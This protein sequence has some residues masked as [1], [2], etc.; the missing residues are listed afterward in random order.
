MPVVAATVLLVAVSGCHDAAT[1]GSEDRP[2]PGVV[3]WRTEAW[4]NLA[5]DVPAHW[6]W[7]TA[8]IAA[9]VDESTSLL[10]GGPG[11]TV[12]ADGSAGGDQDEAWVGRPISLSDVCLTTDQL[13]QPAAPYVWLGADVEPGTVD[14]GGGWVRETVVA[15]DSTLTVATDDPALRRSILESAHGVRRCFGV[16]DTPP[17]AAYGPTEGIRPVRSAEICAYRPEGDEWVLAYADTLDEAAAQATYDALF[18]GQRD[19]SPRFCKDAEEYVA[20]TFTGDDPFG[21]VPVSS[22]VVLSVD[23]RQVEVAPDLVAPLP[24]KALEPWSQNGVRTV[25]FGF[26]GAQG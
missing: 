22:R 21:S 3:A 16:L 23:C 14:L 26:I 24:E 13:G 12:R 9:G 5:V 18:A 10:C 4:R 17:Q 19:S 25:L 2:A 20:I 6:G 1:S 8:P 7:G 15:Y 11:P